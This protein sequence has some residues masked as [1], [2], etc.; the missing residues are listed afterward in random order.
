MSRVA[1][2]STV[3][4]PHST[5]R[6]RTRTAKKAATAPDVFSKTHPARIPQRSAAMLSFAQPA[7]GVRVKDQPI[8]RSRAKSSMSFVRLGAMSPEAREQAV[9]AGVS[10][11]LVDEAAGK[12]GLSQRALLA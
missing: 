6:G 7:S 3:K 5:V 4:R 10:A 11:T 9:T 2:K 1:R 8:S 12:L